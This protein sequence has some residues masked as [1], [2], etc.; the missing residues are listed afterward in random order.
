MNDDIAFLITAPNE[1]IARMWEQ[2]L[3]DASIPTL[4]KP[5]GPGTGGW[6]SVAVSAHELYVRRSDLERAKEIMEEEA[7]AEIDGASGEI[8]E[9]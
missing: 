7:N 4:V 2:M 6:G 9:E 5:E 8:Y 3:V 1:P